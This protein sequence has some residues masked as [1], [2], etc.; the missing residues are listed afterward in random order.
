[1][2]G[3]NPI[4][5]REVTTILRHVRRGEFLRPREVKP[6]IPLPLEAICLKAMAYR[7][8][9]RFASPQVLAHDLELWLADEPVSAWPE[10]PWLKL[11][12]WVNRNRTLVSSTAAALLV[13]LVTGAYLAHEFNL[14]KA[15]RQIEANARVN[16]L[17]TAEVRS[18]PQIVEQL[19]VDRSLVRER[20]NSLL[21]DRSR[22]ASRIGA[23]LALLPD[24]PSQ[25]Q[26]LVD[27][28]MKTEATPEELLVIRDGLRR[29]NALERFIDPLMASLPSPPGALSNTALR[30]LGVV[31]LARPDW[32]RWP[33][34][35][36]RLATKLVQVNPFEIAAWQEVFRPVS[37]ELNPPLPDLFG[38]LPG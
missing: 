29:N 1:M 36:D 13:A 2:T 14:S 34:F 38:P 10:P 8:E 3:Q 5:D 35:A 33:E 31:A 21:S 19:G 17:S 11:R 16:A 6:E 18:V 12:R 37:L 27:H 30:A 4:T 32:S 28:L 22:S 15:R 25:A 24:D 7:P 9:D 26:F 20:L 23:A